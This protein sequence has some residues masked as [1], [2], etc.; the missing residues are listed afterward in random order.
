MFTFAHVLVNILN[1]DI[2]CISAEVCH[3]S[4]QYFAISNA[5]KVAWQKITKITKQILTFVV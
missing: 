4:G 1:M 3:M 2:D 5:E